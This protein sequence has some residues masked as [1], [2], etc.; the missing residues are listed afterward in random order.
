[1]LKLLILLY[2]LL[3]IKYLYIIYIMCIKKG[4]LSKKTVRTVIC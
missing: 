3:I 1:M 4:D 2:N